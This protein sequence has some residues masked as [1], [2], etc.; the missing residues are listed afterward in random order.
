MYIA[1]PEASFSGGHPSTIR[2]TDHLDGLG[3]G[4]TG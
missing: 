3:K 1:S 4:P 2:F